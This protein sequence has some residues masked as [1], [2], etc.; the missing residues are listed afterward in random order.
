[1]QRY[2]LECFLPISFF[3]ME[4]R[5][6]LMVLK[7]FLTL[8]EYKLDFRNIHASQDNNIILSTRKIAHL[9]LLR[10]HSRSTTIHP[11]KY[12]HLNSFFF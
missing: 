9:D 6:F 7:H 11:I 4:F 10:F 8:E 12:L 3:S 2:Y 1:M 5:T